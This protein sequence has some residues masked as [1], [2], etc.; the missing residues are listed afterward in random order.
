MGK[1]FAVANQKGGVG[2]TTL[3]Q[4]LG[5]A[6]NMAIGSRVL[7]IDLDPQGHLTKVW[8][9][10]EPK[11]CM[12]EVLEKRA[13]LCDILVEPDR[14]GYPDLWLAPATAALGVTQ[15]ALRNTI[16]GELELDRALVGHGFD[17]VLIDCPPNLDLLTIN[18]LVAAD[19]ALIPVVP[20]NLGLEGL[21][22]I[23]HTIVEINEKLRRGRR[24]L[25]IL[26]VVVNMLDERL[27]EHQ[28]SLEALALTKLLKA[29]G[30]I[31][32]ATAFAQA[33]R[34]HKPLLTYD[35]NHEQSDALLKMGEWLGTWL[36]GA[37]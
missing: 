36:N 37:A 14:G 2:K 1:I 29:P 23:G 19:Y 10:P 32:R 13:R 21:I 12:S 5:A 7:L 18:A 6:L 30:H 33:Q 34:Q 28:A 4:N 24:K 31:K 16:A 3:T 22:D 11:R 26:S 8:G 17:A 35:L 20:E 25:Y 15:I 9:I 27:T